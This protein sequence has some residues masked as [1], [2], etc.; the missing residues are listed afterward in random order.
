MEP[1]EYG[2][3]QQGAWV[4]MFQ[5]ISQFSPDGIGEH[6]ASLA[7]K[8][9]GLAEFSMQFPP[10]ADHY[11]L[12]TEKDMEEPLRPLGAGG[13]I[14][15]P[16]S[17]LQRQ[18]V[19]RVR[20]TTHGRG[21]G[22]WPMGR[23][24]TPVP[25]VDLPVLAGSWQ[26]HLPP[27]IEAIAP[28]RI[29]FS[30]EDRH[31]PHSTKTDSL[32]ESLIG[33]ELPRRLGLLASSARR[34]SSDPAFRGWQVVN[35][36]LPESGDAIITVYQGHIAST[37]SACLGLI[38]ASIVL[39]LRE[40]QR[41]IGPIIALLAAGAIASEAPLAWPLGWMAVGVMV[42]SGIVLFR[43][44]SKN[45]LT[46]SASLAGRSTIL[47]PARGGGRRSAIRAGN[48]VSTLRSFRSSNCSIE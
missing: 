6:E 9:A 3:V 5:L 13:E 37:W 11:R 15:V 46:T 45:P 10:T 23:F 43:R 34:P 29:E 42:A 36:P 47:L 22:A 17:E 40:P 31:S 39:R 24:E 4:E 21:L 48:R 20:Y 44:R 8:N 30:D 12:V 33:P 1:A 7:I 19:V 25:R 38:A 28:Q 16:L 32:F 26:V 27:G 41:W 18:A 14:R 2:A 35:L